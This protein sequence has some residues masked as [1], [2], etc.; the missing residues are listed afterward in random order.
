KASANVSTMVMPL[1]LSSGISVQAWDGREA[2]GTV[3]DRIGDAEPGRVGAIITVVEGLDAARD[4]RVEAGIDMVA[5]AMGHPHDRAVTY[6]KLSGFEYEICARKHDRLVFPLGIDR[7]I[8]DGTRPQMAA[9]GQPQKA[10]R[11]R[12]GD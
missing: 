5:A 7:D 8:G 11:R 4:L 1:T 12:P 3:G 10:R 9:V 2:T 6:H